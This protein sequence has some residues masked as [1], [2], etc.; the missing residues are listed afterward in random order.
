MK[1][2]KVL[3]WLIGVT[4]MGV[5]L[6]GCQTSPAGDNA[7]GNASSSSLSSSGLLPDNQ[8]IIGR[9]V[10]ISTSPTFEEMIC[11]EL[12]NYYTNMPDWFSWTVS[13][14]NWEA[15]VVFDETTCSN[16]SRV[17]FL[18]SMASNGNILMTTNIVNTN[19]E[20]EY[21]IMNTNEKKVIISTNSNFSVTNGIFGY[22]FTSDTGLTLSL[23]FGSEIPFSNMTLQKQ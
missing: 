17:D 20:L 22:N 11:T 5:S 13:N 21:Y 8:R 4:L 6:V 10:V 16:F 19:S 7:G 2:F 18:F 1:K 12:S 23:E 3:G 14:F 15:L 9:W